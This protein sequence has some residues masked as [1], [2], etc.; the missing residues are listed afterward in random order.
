MLLP[1][2]LLANNIAL[3]QGPVSG[4]SDPSGRIAA[5]EVQDSGTQASLRGLSVVDADIAWA[6]GTTGEVLR[7]VDGGAT[8]NSVAVQ[9]AADLDFRDIQA[10][11]ATEA[12]VISAGSPAKIFQTADGGR[13]WQLVYENHHEQIFFDAME[14]WDRMRGIAF[15][16]P[17]QGRLVVIRTE[18][19]GRTWTELDRELCPATLDGEA[20][21]AASGTCLTIRPGGHVWIGLGGDH[22]TD[23]V[24]PVRGRVLHSSDSGATWTSHSSTLPATATSG[25][26]SLVMADDKIGVAAGGDYQNPT[27]VT[28]N[29]ARTMDGGKSWVSPSGRGP[30]GFRSAVAVF[31]HG[32]RRMFIAVGTTGADYSV[33]DGDTWQALVDTPLHTVVFDPDGSAGWG[34]GGEGTIVA[35]DVEQLAALFPPSQ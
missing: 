22:S 18:D 11:S 12:V 28:G 29:V 19:G 30:R 8:W 6:S 27:A 3:G 24:E 23:A 4:P 17:I 34:S 33:D 10:F 16:D 25:V 1:A 7:T 2:A 9:T 14:F 20:G 26:F 31:R 21:F 35:W 13:T 5:V 32:H 15:G